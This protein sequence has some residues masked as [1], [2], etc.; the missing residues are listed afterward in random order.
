MSA[1][2]V[3]SRRDD[4][5]LRP[6]LSPLAIVSFG[7][8]LLAAVGGGDAMA[9][10]FGSEV[11]P[12]L[13]RHC[14]T[15][16]GPDEEA[17]EAGLRLDVRDAAVADLG[18]Y[19]AVEPGDAEE[20]EIF[21]RVTSDDPDMRMPPADRH[22]PLTESE[23]D[24]LRRWIDDGAT[25]ETH[26][27][28]VPPR[29]PPIP[30]AGGDVFGPQKDPSGKDQQ[31]GD[32]R[33]P[34]N[35]KLAGETRSPIDRFVLAR[36]HDAGLSPSPEADRETLIRRLSLDLNGTVPTEAEIE[37]FVNDPRPDAY[38]RLVE[39][40]LAS[41][42][43]AERFAR[44]WLDLAR[45]A[46]TNGYE[47]DRARTIWPYRDWVIRA[48]AEDMPYDRFS[49]EQLAGDMLPDAT[50]EQRIA[51]GFHRNTMLNEEGGIDP[52]EYRYHALVDRV[53]TTGTV[54]LG[55]TTGCAQ[56]HTHKYDP[57]TH[58]DYFALMACFD[59][60]DEPE[61]AVPD[62]TVETQRRRIRDEI[63]RLELELIRE[64]L[65][66]WET[67]ESAVRNGPA[68]QTPRE[69]VSPEDATAP[70]DSAAAN[71]AALTDVENP[72]DEAMPRDEAAN[73]DGEAPADAFMRFV[74]RQVDA[75]RAWRV[76][77][78]SELRSTMPKLSLL[79]DGSVLASGDVTKRDVYEMTLAIPESLTRVTALRLEVLPH[80]SLPA[81]GPGMAYYEGRRGDF[82]L[83]K[84]ELFRESQ[85][86]R[87]TDASHSFGKISVGS[88]NADADNVIDG[89]GSTGWSTAGAEGQANR[90]VARLADP[91]HGGQT[92]R[93]RMVF[94][95]HFAAALGRFRLSVTEGPPPVVASQL[96]AEVNEA[97]AVAAGPASLS[98]EIY[99]ELQRH[100]VRHAE[101]MA[102]F[103]QPLERLVRSLPE[104]TRSLVMRE[105]EPEDRRVT[106]RHHRGEYLQPREPVAPGLPEL[107]AGP[108][109]NGPEE[110]GAVRDRLTLARW[111]ASEENPLV[112]RVA[113]N[114]AWRHFFGTGI[115]RTA[116]DFGTQS[117]PPSHPQ[118]LDWLATDWMRHGWSMK[119]LH[120]QIVLSAT[121]RQRVGPAP[122]VDPDHRL[123]SAMPYR[124]LEAEVIRDAFLAAAR[125][126]DRGVGGPSVYPPQPSSVTA[127]AYGNSP[128]PVSDGGDRFRRSLYTFA[129][130]TAPFAA[131]TT[132]DGPTGE[133]CLAR[134]D[135]STTPLQSLTL[136][137]D[138]MYVELARELA[139]DILRGSAPENAY[140]NAH[141]EEQIATRIFRR[142]L[143]RP[144]HADERQAI[145]AFYRS[146]RQRIASDDVSAERSD[147][148]PSEAAGPSEAERLRAWTLVARALM[149]TDEAI[150]IP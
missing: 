127:I 51:T 10:D 97:L 38:R 122:E 21:L 53:A 132:F 109:E 93:L 25:Y 31:R 67:F 134:R 129:K 40:M 3:R 111:L 34:E 36:L 14:L 73:P 12:I 90:W 65:P 5:R 99:A 116:G 88:G 66:A 135:R 112:A 4:R 20:S 141:D 121:Y 89:E 75:A 39:R 91:L 150:T 9:V 13:A 59:G 62:E 8:V 46:D 149:N 113:V 102:D 6:R 49:V 22:P 32:D 55:L 56:C 142:L 29:T 77:R 71:D 137:N 147:A 68:A 86:I 15:C 50:A 35:S 146:V 26:W 48:I 41:P 126:L 76:I 98:P 30:E 148:A 100:F 144:P 108:E 136:M 110:N 143:S 42:A 82:F 101:P 83:S 64:H 105:R 2:H 103:R 69:A 72:P 115:V 18:G 19:R 117:E 128:W 114:R 133:T 11:R 47:K 118:L 139:R 70:E 61:M 33:T 79:E 87:M 104:P 16:H 140:E 54:W 80:E 107:F 106:H 60:A 17:R 57:I 27:A 52:L 45:Y 7:S 94:E 37:A 145:V 125:L 1:L 44:T 138:E 95:R 96:S 74:E 24:T 120:R 58:T 130:R 78:P 92:V 43:Y 84:L 81:G 131:F 119:R 23:I 85:P 28:F 124:R 123:L 63:A